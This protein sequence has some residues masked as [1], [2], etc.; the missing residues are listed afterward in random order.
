MSGVRGPVSGVRGPGSAGIPNKNPHRH[1]E[2]GIQG[3]GSGV[4][5]PGSGVRGRPGIPMG[6]CDYV[7]RTSHLFVSRI[8]LAPCPAAVSAH[9]PARSR[10]SP[11][12]GMAGLETP[13]HLRKSRAGETRNRVIKDA[14]PRPERCRAGQMRYRR[15]KDT[16]PPLPRPERRRAGEKRHRGTKDTRPTSRPERCRAGEKR[17]R[18][19]EEETSLPLEAALEPSPVVAAEFGG[20]RRMTAAEEAA[21]RARGAPACGRAFGEDE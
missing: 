18:V 4:R 13:R 19:T 17:N 6:I 5:C 20:V 15:T 8:I 16:R 7:V 12:S 2:S 10:P 11:T 21:W 3:P 1:P 9:A 14:R